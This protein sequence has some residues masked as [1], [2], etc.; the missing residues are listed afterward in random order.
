[1]LSKQFKIS[2]FTIIRNGVEFDFPFIESFNSILPVV[3]EFVINIGI[4]SDQTKEVIQKWVQSLSKEN[5]S[6]IRTFDSNWP[7]DDPE[8]KKGGRILAD[9]TNMALQKCLG[10]WC[11]YLQADEVVH[12]EDYAEI[13]NTVK[14]A[15]LKSEIQAIVFQYVHF[16]G[17]FNVIQTSRSSYRREIRIVRN[18]LGIRSTGDAQSFL[19]ADGSKLNAI[20]TKA[21]IFHYGWVRPQETMKKKTVFM[22]SLY[23]QK[24]TDAKEDLPATGDNYLYKRFVGLHSFKGTHPKVM[25][26]RLRAATM[27]DIDKLP[28]VFETKDIWKVI[29]G[30]IEKITGYRPFEFKNYKLIK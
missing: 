24:T 30:W 23:H 20:L 8:Q 3:D 9:Q 18:H 1:M 10:D 25:S 13:L 6:K 22:D 14:Q 12:E 2:A 28:F 19:H 7:L 4:S 17:N 26:N 5:A 27:L 16:Y 21:R 29:S 11:F 15:N